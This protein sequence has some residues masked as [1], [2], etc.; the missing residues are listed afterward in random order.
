MSERDGDLVVIG[1]LGRPH[2][3]RGEIRARATGPTL[4]TLTAGAQVDVVRDGGATRLTVGG[5][6]PAGDDFIVSFTDVVAREAAAELTGGTIRV[7][8]ADL[9]A[10]SAPDEYFVRDLE[11]LRVVTH[12][13]GTE[14]GTVTRVHSGAA[15]D[16]LEVA[17]SEPPVVLLPFT[18]DAVVRLSLDEGVIVVRDDLLGGADA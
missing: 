13:A 8:N 5:I 15:N 6:R 14:L 7:P 2:G 17:G 9:S 4:A 11:G 18:H 1:T 3:V 10:P 12:P 16:V